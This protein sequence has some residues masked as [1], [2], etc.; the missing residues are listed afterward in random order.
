VRL[1]DMY[2]PSA[3]TPKIHENNGS[4]IF[5]KLICT[6]YPVGVVFLAVGDVVYVE[7]IFGSF[8]DYEYEPNKGYRSEDPWQ[9]PDEQP[10]A[11]PEAA[12]RLLF[13]MAW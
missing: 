1:R 6:D 8:N 13:P 2:C 3:P 7:S 11:V 4:R 9:L 5:G 12:R 10:E